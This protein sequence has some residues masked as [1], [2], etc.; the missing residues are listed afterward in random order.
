MM[1][2]MHA[3]FSCPWQTGFPE[4]QQVNSHK[5][6]EIE[7]IPRKSVIDNHTSMLFDEA[8]QT[9]R[10]SLP[11]SNYN[12]NGYPHAGELLQVCLQSSALSPFPLGRKYG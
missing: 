11:K 4:C 5:D 9:R 1:C 7:T 10:A 3:G 2:K 6:A 8:R 12:P